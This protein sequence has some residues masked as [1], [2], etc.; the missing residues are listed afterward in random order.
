MREKVAVFLFAFIGLFQM[1]YAQHDQIHYLKEGISFTLPEKWQIIADEPIPETGYYLSA[2]RTGKNSTGLFTLTWLNKEDD[3]SKVILAQMESMKNANLYRN[4]GIE[5]TAIEDSK[6]V[7]NDCKTVKY[8]SI[9]HEQKI[10]GTIWCF[11]CSGRTLIVFFQSGME[12]MKI[13]QKGFSE[14]QQTFGCR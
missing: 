11:N 7:G 12:D 9:I 2:E 5:F 4:S 1:A 10:E 6:F 8:Q 13:N 14:I 3:P